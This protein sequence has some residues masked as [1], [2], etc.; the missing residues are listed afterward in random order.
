M[1]YL[2]VHVSIVHILCVKMHYYFLLNIKHGASQLYLGAQIQLWG[3]RGGDAE[4]GSEAPGE[5]PLRGPWGLQLSNAGTVGDRGTHMCEQ[6][7]QSCYL[8]VNRPRV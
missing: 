5:G 3:S 2:H 4:G 1:F 6:L 8:T 7:A